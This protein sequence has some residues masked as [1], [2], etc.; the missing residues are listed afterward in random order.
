MDTVKR[1]RV[2]RTLLAWGVIGILGIVCIVMGIG[3]STANG[4]LSF[5]AVK[6]TAAGS[7]L[8]AIAIYKLTR[9]ARQQ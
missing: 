3:R 7:I 2:T 5:E 4:S 6:F 9:G 1:F 8:L